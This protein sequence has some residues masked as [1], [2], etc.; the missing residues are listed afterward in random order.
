MNTAKLI[1]DNLPGFNGHA[2]LYELDPPIK[3]ENEKTHKRVIVSAAYAMFTGAETYIF[4]AKD[5]SEE[6]EDW[7]ELEG[8]YRGGMSHAEALEGAGYAIA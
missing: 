6:V 7:G 4:P 8:S 3:G 5:D 1:K 2:A